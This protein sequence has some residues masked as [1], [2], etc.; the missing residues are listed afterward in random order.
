MLEASA[1]G[2]EYEGYGG[3]MA[4]VDGCPLLSPSS[5]FPASGF[6]LS[7]GLFLT[8]IDEITWENKYDSIT[9]VKL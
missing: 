9:P 3:P 8:N 7:C 2:L 4:T 5:K 6:I 1:H